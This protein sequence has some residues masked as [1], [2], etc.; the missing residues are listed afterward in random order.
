MDRMSEKPFTHLCRH[1]IQVDAPRCD[2]R[3]GVTVRTP[4]GATPTQIAE[5]VAQALGYHAAVIHPGL[6]SFAGYDAI[7]IQITTS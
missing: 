5:A 6:R 3:G 4:E 1:G 2:L 7:N